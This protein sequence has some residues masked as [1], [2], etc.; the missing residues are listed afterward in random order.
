MNNLKKKKKQI[1]EWVWPLW[2]RGH[3][4]LASNYQVPTHVQIKN[5]FVSGLDIFTPIATISS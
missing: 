4:N 2:K 5:I 1:H 3:A